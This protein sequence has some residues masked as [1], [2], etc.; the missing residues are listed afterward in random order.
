MAE[1][2]KNALDCFLVASKWV[3]AIGP[4]Y[5]GNDIPTSNQDDIR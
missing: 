1:I 2:E 4:E 3:G 5:I